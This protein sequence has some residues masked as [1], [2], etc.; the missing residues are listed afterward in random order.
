ML[1]AQASVWVVPSAMMIGS[2]PLMAYSL[3]WC[4]RG[5]IRFQIRLFVACMTFAPVPQE[6][7]ISDRAQP[8]CIDPPCKKVCR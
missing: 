7:S 2:G 8:P 4:R 1:E 5:V 3:F 6:A